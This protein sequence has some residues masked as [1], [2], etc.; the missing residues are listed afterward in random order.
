MAVALSKELGSPMR[1]G[2]QTLAWI[3]AAMDAGMEDDDFTRLYP[4][5]DKLKE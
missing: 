2:H 3:Q 4:M 5:L 1:I